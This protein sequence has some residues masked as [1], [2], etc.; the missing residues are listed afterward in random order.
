MYNY[1]LIL[2]FCVVLAKLQQ[3][4]L[5]TKYLYTNIMVEIGWDLLLLLLL[6]EPFF[7]KAA[8]N[9]HKAWSNEALLQDFHKATPTK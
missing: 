1:H 9:S 6:L 8:S 5:S 2:L 7:Y 4:S 3:I